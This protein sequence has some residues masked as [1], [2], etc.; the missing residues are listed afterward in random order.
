MTPNNHTLHALEQLRRQ[1]ALV[2]ELCDAILFG[3]R[4]LAT[5]A[6]RQLVPALRLLTSRV[7]L[8]LDAM[9]QESTP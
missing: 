5:G 1:S 7:Q 3:Q 2:V 4:S 9:E 8:T 6:T